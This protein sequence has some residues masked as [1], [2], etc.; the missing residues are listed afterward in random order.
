MKIAFIT[1]ITGQDGSYLSELLLEKDYIVFGLIRRSSNFNTQ[2]IQHIF[3]NPKLNLRYGDL[4]DI[5]SI[6][7]I[8]NEIKK[9]EPEVIEFYNL[10]AQS[11]VG[12]SF[13]SPLNT[14][15]ITG[16]G[17]LRILETIR[18]INPKIKFYQ[19]SSSEMFGDVLEKKQNEKTPFN[20]QSPYAIAKVLGHYSTVNYRES[21]NLFA[22]S[23]ILFNHESPFRGEE[24]VTRKII[25]GLINIINQKQKYLELGNIY[26]K[27]DWGFAKEYVEIMWRMLQN[28][29]P[30]DYVVSTGKTY[31]VKQFIDESTKYLKIK[32]KWIGKGL[33]QKLINKKN[34]RVIIKINKKY[35]RPS[36]VNYLRGDSSKAQ[37]ELKW[38]PKTDLK[39]LVKIMIDEEIKNFNFLS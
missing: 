31:S 38:K 8:L 32:T 9:L 7:N 20:P 18:S 15:N 4:T 34:N 23:G 3:G 28:R 12:T 29:K 6:I 19:A 36:E 13:R 35:F 22:V 39:K 14:S 37:K 10:A 17:T 2:R 1:G 30:R 33:N 26:A 27:R 11:F 25:I 24:F 21:Y 16:L 5:V